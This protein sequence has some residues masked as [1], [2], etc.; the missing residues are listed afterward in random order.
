[1]SITINHKVTYSV[2]RAARR[3]WYLLFTQYGAMHNEIR[4]IH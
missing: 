4:I 2:L 1:M 3:T